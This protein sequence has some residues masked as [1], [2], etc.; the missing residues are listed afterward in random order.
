[1]LLMA[2]VAT[3]DNESLV[4]GNR[5]GNNAVGLLYSVNSIAEIAGFMRPGD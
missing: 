2:V 1:M 3:D 4:L 5:V